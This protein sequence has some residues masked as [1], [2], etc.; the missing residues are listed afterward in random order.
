MTRFRGLSFS[1]A[2]IELKNYGF[3]NRKEIEKWQIISQVYFL[4]IWRM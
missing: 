3:Y 1:S 2:M 4:H